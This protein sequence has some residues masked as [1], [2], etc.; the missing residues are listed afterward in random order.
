VV[1]GLISVLCLGIVIMIIVGAVMISQTEP[2]DSI[3]VRRTKNQMGNF[4][5]FPRSTYRTKEQNYERLYGS[6]LLYYV[7]LLEGYLEIV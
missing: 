6:L 5:R 7:N 1:I 2:D 4:S 3:F